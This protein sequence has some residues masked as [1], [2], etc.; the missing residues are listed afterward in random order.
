M[1]TLGALMRCGNCG[2]KVPAGHA[3]CPR[4]GGVPVDRMAAGVDAALDAIDPAAVRV[5]DPAVL[6]QAAVD[7][8]VRRGFRVVSQTPTTAQLVK[9]KTFHFVL[10]LVTLLLFGLGL[11]YLFWY[12]AQKDTQVYLTIDADGRLRVA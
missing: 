7:D 10:F 1:A 4:C 12:L 8:Y 5:A 3:R 9:P 11:L 2:K 6:L